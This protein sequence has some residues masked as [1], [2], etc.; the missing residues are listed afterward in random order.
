MR[1][2]FHISPHASHRQYAV[3]SAFSPGDL[4][5]V[6]RQNGHAVGTTHGT[7]G[8]RFATLTPSSIPLEP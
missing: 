2:R 7:S 3:T 1:A 8:S 4:I 6:A 5:V